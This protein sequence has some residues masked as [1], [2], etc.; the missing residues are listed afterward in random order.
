MTGELIGLE[1]LY[2]QTGRVLEVV[3]LDPDPFYFR[4][5]AVQTCLLLAPDSALLFSLIFLFFL[6]ERL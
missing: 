3:S 5:L 2:Q 1:Y 4:L 6:S